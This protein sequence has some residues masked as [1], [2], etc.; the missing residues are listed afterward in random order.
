MLYLSEVLSLPVID[1][2][3]RVLGRVAD[4]T[5]RPASK[6]PRLALI[7]M[8]TGRGSHRYVSWGEVRAFEATQIILSQR[9]AELSAVQL[10]DSDVLL[11]KNVLDKQIVDL[12]G[13]KL[14]R[15]QDVQLARTGQDIQ[16]LGVDVSTSALVR[17]LGFR[18]LAD[19]IARRFPPPA[20]DWHDVNL[21]DW[22]DPNL[23]LRLRKES[24]NRLHPAD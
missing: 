9:A 14:V 18:R 21:T 15:V 8:R 13:R 20:V 11:A 2:Q 10:Q 4:L 7:K 5:A 1:S 12:E 24:V 19:A 17:R 23:K 6:Y 22:R 3:D 16:V